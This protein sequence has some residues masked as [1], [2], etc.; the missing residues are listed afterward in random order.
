MRRRNAWKATVLWAM[1]VL[2][3]MTAAI[4]QEISGEPGSPSATTT[5]D[6]KRLPPPVPKFGGV[7]KENAA[8]RRRS[9]RRGSCRPRGRRTCS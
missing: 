5:I 2:W 8:S 4:A 6:G 7:I 1:A 9:G 3:A